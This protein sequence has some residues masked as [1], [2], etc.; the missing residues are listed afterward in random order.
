[1]IKAQKTRSDIDICN[2]IEY[3][4][5]SYQA[6][7][8]IVKCTKLRIKWLKFNPSQKNM[9][10]YPISMWRNKKN[11]NMKWSFKRFQFE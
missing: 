1:M 8:P 4:M 3:N 9:L 7:T 5:K 10:V 11:L 2:T 6:K